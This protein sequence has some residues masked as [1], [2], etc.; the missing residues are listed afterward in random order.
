VRDKLKHNIDF[1]LS[2]DESLITKGIAICLML[3]HHLF[4]EY[5]EYGS[6]V[7]QS[8]QFGKVCVSLF[9]F[10]SAYGLTIQYGKVFDKPI[11]GTFKFLIKRFVKFYANYWIVFLIFVPVGIFVFEHSLNVPYGTASHIKMLIKDILGINYIFS[12]NITWWFNFLIIT[13]YLLFPFLYFVAKKYPILLLV[14]SGILWQFTIPL[15]PLAVHEWLFSFSLGIVYVLNID[16]INCFLNRINPWLLFGSLLFIFYLLYYVRLYPIIPQFRETRVDGFLTVNIVIL[17][18]LTIRKIP[19]L[20]RAVS[21]L[22][23]HSMN[24]YMIHTFIFYYW[25]EEFI[26]S[27]KYPIL[28]FVV[29]MAIC[30]VISICVEYGKKMIHLPDL[31]KTINNKIENKI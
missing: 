12:Y 31:I 6:F 24:V 26:Y 8:A 1:R 4:Y 3:W 28:I 25:F 20:A 27:F 23:K 21:F 13:L 16:R 5:P 29:L 10:V 7:F 11:S 2:L 18:I 9:L 14:V 30:I 15:L 17:L 19:K 22:G